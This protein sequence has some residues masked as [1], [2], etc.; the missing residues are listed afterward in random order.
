MAMQSIL[1]LGRH[2]NM[3]R[4][5][6]EISSRAEL[7]AKQLRMHHW[8]AERRLFTDCFI[9]GKQ[10]TEASVHINILAILAGLADDPGGL[11][12]RTWQKPGITQIVG[13]FFRVH[14]FEVLDRLGRYSDI[15]AEI[16]K[17]WGNFV[18]SGLTST[19][20]YGEW[21]WPASLGH[22]WGASPAIYLVKSI[23]GLRPL[24]PG[25]KEAE[26]NPHLCGLKHVFVTV[27]TP[28]GPFSVDLK[29]KSGKITATFD[30]PDQI[31]L[32]FAAFRRPYL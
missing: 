31:K 5:T 8:D 4:R 22:P 7:L 3:E 32:H 30:K 27:P 23:A 13:P 28:F 17:L 24:A 15:L 10:S 14:L 12:D 11:L 25:W 2:L 6:V 19:P 18:K 16:R 9:D 20:E 26:F 29:K 21:D 1:W